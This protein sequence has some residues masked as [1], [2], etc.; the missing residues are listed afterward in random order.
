M[1]SWQL[2]LGG[3]LFALLPLLN[4]LTT[5]IHVVATMA[6]GD[7]GLAGVDLIA[8][9]LGLC[10]FYS[11]RRM[12][13]RQPPLSAAEKRRQSAAAAGAAGAAA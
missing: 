13:R 1:W 8:F 9:A 3:A 7:W 10:L 11:G 6:A 2:Y 4:A 12:Q 5:P